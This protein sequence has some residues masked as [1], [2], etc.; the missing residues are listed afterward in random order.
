MAMGCSYR[1]SV[2]STHMAAYNVCTPVPGHLDLITSSGLYWYQAHMC[3]M[4]IH[5]NKIL[6]QKKTRMEGV[7]QV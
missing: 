6:I 5:S 7:T 1:G 4:Y 3:Y 2:P